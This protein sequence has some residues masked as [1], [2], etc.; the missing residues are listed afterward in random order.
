MKELNESESFDRIITIS[1]P[2]RNFVS[3]IHAFIFFR[4]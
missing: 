4:R 2:E 1:I 3:L